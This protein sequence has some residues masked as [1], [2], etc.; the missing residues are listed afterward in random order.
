M[1][2]EDAGRP[3]H[4]SGTDG[5]QSSALASRSTQS[6]ASP[7]RERRATNSTYKVGDGTEFPRYFLQ[8][9][10]DIK[11][12]RGYDMIQE[13][14]LM[15][16][17]K[18]TGIKGN[19]A[20]ARVMVLLREVQ[21]PFGCTRLGCMCGRQA[22]FIKVRNGRGVKLA[23]QRSDIDKPP[24]K[25]IQ[26]VLV[27]LENKV[28]A[29][30]YDLGVF[31]V[32]R[33]ELRKELRDQKAKEFQPLHTIDFRSTEVKDLPHKL[34]A[35]FEDNQILREQVRQLQYSLRSAEARLEVSERR[36]AALETENLQL[37][38]A[39]RDAG[40][41]VD[42]AHDMRQMREAARAAEARAMQ[43]DMQLMSVTEQL[44]SERRL[45][46]QKARHAAAR[47]AML[48]SRLAQAL[49]TT[50][51]PMSGR[52][53]GG[54]GGSG[55]GTARKS[56]ARSGIVYDPMFT[57]DGGSFSGRGGGG[58]VEPSGGSVYAASSLLDGGTGGGG[59]I[60]AAAAAAAA[61]AL[62]ARS[63]VHSRVHSTASAGAGRSSAGRE[64][65]V[66]PPR[67]PSGR[68]ISHNPGSVIPTLYPLFNAKQRPIHAFSGESGS[69][70]NGTTPGSG[71]V[72]AA[73]GSSGSGATGG[74]AA[75]TISGSGLPPPAGL[76]RNSSLTDRPMARPSSGGVAHGSTG[77]AIELLQ[78]GRP[79]SSTS[80]S[81]SSPGEL[82]RAINS[83]A[84]LTSR[85]LLPSV[86]GASSGRPGGSVAG[87]GGG[88]AA[89]GILG[90]RVGS[91]VGGG[92]ASG[93]AALRR[94]TGS[95][96]LSLGLAPAGAAAAA[97]TGGEATG[98]DLV[99]R[100]GGSNPVEVEEPGRVG[101]GAAAA[102]EAV[103]A[104]GGAG[105]SRQ[106]VAVVVAV[107]VVVVVEPPPF[108]GAFS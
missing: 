66:S 46:M 63:S 108:L 14:Q 9:G 80:T 77:T 67:S 10:Q 30:T 53:V 75:G 55:G 97:A 26:G 6:H 57:D 2:Q 3:L 71:I 76:V 83:S 94:S 85:T 88:A 69:W 95:E 4:S 84:V 92:G 38:I 60:A 79:P 16:C 23:R 20:R 90:L 61:A 64:R 24:T 35:L 65:S 21:P 49:S 45:A 100:P 41:S 51:P 33:S 37:G 13:L 1:A 93:I 73:A 78:D 72:G 103:E 104:E 11:R 59:G 48:E 107:V 62:D 34:R 7:S 98:Q 52:F 81:T 44:E 68:S 29:Q 91:L 56:S 5:R 27:G 42:I 58:G 70:L 22:L 89:P 54:G 19:A 25:C 43:L 28:D 31:N 74:G 86:S 12:T 18:E 47:Q 102:V 17:N 15:V 96:D 40:S 50:T 32:E 82:V 99:G 105:G 8:I 106:L 36:A 101:A 39:L 87:G